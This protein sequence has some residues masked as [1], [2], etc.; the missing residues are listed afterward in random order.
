MYCLVHNFKNKELPKI[1]KEFVLF[2]ATVMYQ[3]V[4]SSPLGPLVI[5]LSEKVVVSAVFTLKKRKT[6]KE[7]YPQE[8]NNMVSTIEHMLDAY[9]LHNKPFPKKV[10]KKLIHI[11]ELPGTGFQKKV[12]SAIAVIPHGEVIDYTTLAT[13]IGNLKAVRAVGTACGKNPLALFIPCHR[14]VRKR[15]EDYGYSWGP[16]RKKYLLDHENYKKKNFYTPQT[17]N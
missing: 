7:T 8:I 5:T 15:G 14:V 17:L 16:E 10:L 2:Y 3:F 12:W 4:Y 6:K 9:F 13:R 11:D 1:A